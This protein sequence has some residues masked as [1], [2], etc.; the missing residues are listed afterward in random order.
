MQGGEAQRA[1]RQSP[2]PLVRER[3]LQLD[4]APPELRSQPQRREQPERLVAQPPERDLEHAGRG[5]VEP[6]DVV[7]RDEARAA[8][9]QGAQHVEHGEP[10]RVRVGR[11]LARLREQK[12][13][14]ERP[15]ARRRERRAR[16]RRARPRAAP[17]ARRTR[18]RPRPRRPG[19]SGSSRTGRARRRRRP[20]TAPSSRCP[21]R[22][23][24][25]ARAARARYR[26][27][28]PG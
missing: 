5:R 8:V 13:D 17:R 11:R 10:D 1:H 9:G 15:P 27:G 2:E 24:A 23:R 3:A 4:R 22:R 18:V 21:P 19:R 16:L 26:P 20:P 25:R 12:R 7:E 14:L 28:I 6:L